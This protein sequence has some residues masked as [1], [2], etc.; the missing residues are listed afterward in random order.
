MLKL[1]PTIKCVSL[2]TVSHV[3]AIP[4]LEQPG[5]SPLMISESHH[6]GAHHRTGGV[7]HHRIDGGLA[8]QRIDHDRGRG[9]TVIQLIAIGV[10]ILEE[11]VA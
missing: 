10:G 2:N 6:I 7:I 11:V 4:F 1:Y 5:R 8:A 9:L 3:G